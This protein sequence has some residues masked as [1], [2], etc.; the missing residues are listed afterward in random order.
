LNELLSVTPD[1][2]FLR[3]QD[4]ET[5]ASFAALGSCR[6]FPKNNI[7]FHHSDPCHAAYVVVSGRIKLVLASEDGRELALEIFGPG[8]I[9]GLVATLDRGV[10]VGTAITISQTRLAI[11][12]V[13]RL[14]A[15]LLERPR[16]YQQVAVSLAHIIR[17]T[18][19]R[20]G[21]Q[22]LLTVKRRVHATLLDIARHEGTATPGSTDLIAPRPTHQEIAERVGS[23]RVVVS[24]VLK[25]LLEEE[26]SISM[27]G[28]TLRVHLHA[29]ESAAAE[30][31]PFS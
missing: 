1:I 5:R 27:E 30:A 22:A 23:S 12:P 28:R 8:D 31:G 21:M 25:E 19:E 6:T 24:R 17:Q 3:D 11:L 26:D 15:W 14:H 16:L 18:Y 10:H 4:Q 2:F 9:F 7:L 13:D 29:V 20:V